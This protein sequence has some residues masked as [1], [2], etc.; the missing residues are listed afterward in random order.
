MPVEIVGGR[1]VLAQEPSRAGGTAHVHRAHDNDNDQRVVAVKLYDGV[2]HDSDVLR[3]CFYREREALTTLG[4]PHIVEFV[5]AGY[6]DERQ[7]HYVAMEW[8][9]RPL[10]AHLAERHRRLPLP[11]P[12]VA[13]EVLGPLL[14]ALA[15]A[16]A[17]RVVHRDVKPANVMVGADG[18]V[19]LT[20]FGLA[21]LLE[22]VRFGLT[23]SHFRSEPYAPPE[24]LDGAVG[25]RGDLYALGM[26]ALRFLVSDP[27]LLKADDL[28]AIIKGCGIDTDGQFMLNW[29]TQ[30]EVDARPR[31]AK[32][33]RHE[34][35]KLL[36]HAPKPDQGRRSRLQIIITQAARDQ[37]QGQLNQPDAD[38]AARALRADLRDDDVAL[39]RQRDQPAGWGAHESAVRLDLIGTELLHT[40]KFA[41]EGTGALILTGIRALPPAVLERRR[42]AAMPLRHE[43]VA[44]SGWRSQRDDA[45]A[46]IEQLA[47]FEAEE[48]AQR[49]QREESQLFDRW[50][51]LLEA[52]K[53]LE[54]RREDPLPFDQ[55]RR[56]PGQVIFRT[57]SDVDERYLEQTRRVALEP[58]G[59]VI[60]EIVG[61]GARELTMIVQRGDPA[62]LPAKGTLR[63][64]S[65]PSKQAIERQERALQD[66]RDG[67]GARPDLGSI[68]ARPEQADPLSPL[69]PPSALQPLDEPKHHAV[70]VALASPDFT[71]VQGPP[72]T[73]KTTFIAELM[74]QELNSREETRILLSA[75]TH[76]AVDAAATALAELMP[77]RRVVRVGR[78][79][80]IDPSARKLGVDEQL[81]AW[82]EEVRER[83]RSWL[84]AWGEERGLDR[85]AIETYALAGE[86]T[87]TLANL[88]RI[89]Q[90][91]THLH[92]EEHRLLDI[93]TDPAREDP[94]ATTTT[95][96][97]LDDQDELAA[98]QDEIE[99]RTAEKGSLS[100]AR[101]RLTGRLSEQVGRDVRPNEDLTAVLGE[102]FGLDEHQLEHLLS[103]SALQ[104]EWLVRF[105]QGTDFRDALLSSAPVVAGTCVGLASVLADDAAFD[106]AVVD[107]AS[108][109]T[110]TEALV[111]MVRSRRWVIVG[112]PQQLPPYVDAELADQLVLK[113]HGLTRADL[114]ETLFTQLAEH[115]P[116]DRQVILS[117]QHRMLAPI[118]ELISH[119]FYDGKLKSARG[120]R[121]DLQCL[122]ATGQPPVLWLS[123]SRLG[124][125]RRE[126]QVGTTYWNPGEVREICRY[127]ERLQQRAVGHNETVKVGVLS[128][129]GEQA[130]RLQ[131]D[132]RPRDAKW[133]NLIIDVHPVDSFQGQQR[134][135]VVYSVTRSNKDDDLGFLRAEERINVALSRGRDGLVI[136]GDARFWSRARG[137]DTPLA[138]VLA[139][140]QSAHGCSVVECQP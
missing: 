11:W 100:H 80:K 86:L 59:H 135:V 102:T 87:S 53:D 36:V 101:D 68:L 71:L 132:I 138:K 52:K 64:D 10:E 109:A 28:Q 105:G 103:L 122:A 40:A 93:L 23:V 46:L 18:I 108:K 30:R 1:F 91:L 4:H 134:D 20:D 14:D 114:G 75:Q 118:G 137:G 67:Q 22:S 119:C 106:L 88:G 76:I 6:D 47:T 58:A 117:T 31:T 112:D 127:L 57:T 124:G 38:A 24:A 95:D 116:G 60:G 12:V 136:V 15:A 70:A 123:T 63:V 131:R 37:A 48:A 7:Q 84:T 129:Y 130:R 51:E 25:Q 33:A 35:E 77:Q 133:T 19:K 41:E 65:G 140:M 56:E 13:R 8:L 98:V 55:V 45:D 128:G 29:L 99:A 62:A 9:E 61:V 3:E 5:A 97:T 72:G 21:K 92:A 16:H 115:L 82:G 69:E 89:E 83:A 39:A 79:E 27:A 26:T 34:L 139:H 54:R 110:P 90:R 42:E 49:I 73:G 50:S 81:T 107:E 74:A 113:R 43:L 94:D 125:T 121:S 32:L 111:P 66:V 96:S 85:H 126:R 44:T 2:G 17:R 78:P 104:D 120:D